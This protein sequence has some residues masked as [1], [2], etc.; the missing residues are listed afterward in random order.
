MTKIELKTSFS[1]KSQFSWRSAPIRIPRP[2]HRPGLGPGPR[3]GLGPAR[4]GQNMELGL[5]KLLGQLNVSFSMK[6]SFIVIF[7][8]KQIFSY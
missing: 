8:M 4:P 3:P 5:V 1:S 2:Y 6:R 7:S